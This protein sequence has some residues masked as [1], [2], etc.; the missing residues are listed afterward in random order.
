MTLDTYRSGAISGMF[1]TLPSSCAAAT[2]GLLDRLVA[3][4]LSL[5]Q[6]NFRFPRAS[7]NEPLARFVLT[8]IMLQGY[9]LHR[10]AL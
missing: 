10:T 4:D 7:E 5:I 6:R 9:A 3:L 2:V 1:V 8:E